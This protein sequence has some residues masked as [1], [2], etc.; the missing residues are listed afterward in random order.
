MS[1]LNQFID[2]HLIKGLTTLRRYS[3]AIPKPVAD[4]AEEETHKGL[5]PFPGA[6]WFWI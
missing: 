1:L 5:A 3:G 6:G 4:M 2:Q